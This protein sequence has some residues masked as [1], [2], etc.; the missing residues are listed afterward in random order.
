MA[1]KVELLSPPPAS[2]GGR[3]QLSFETVAEACLRGAVRSLG[4]LGRLA[5]YTAAGAQQVCPVQDSFLEPLPPCLR[6]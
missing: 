2:G 1:P 3:P 4:E 5:A 6:F